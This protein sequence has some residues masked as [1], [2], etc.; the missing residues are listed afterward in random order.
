MRER[1]CKFNG[2]VNVANKRERYTWIFENRNIAI[3]V[4]ATLTCC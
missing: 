4:A 3:N 2:D 1:F